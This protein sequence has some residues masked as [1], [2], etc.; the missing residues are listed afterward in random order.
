[1][2]PDDDMR[3]ARSLGNRDPAPV[4]SRALLCYDDRVALDVRD[5]REPV[6]AKAK[7]A[8]PKRLAQLAARKVRKIAAKAAGAPVV[9]KPTPARARPTETPRKTP[10]QLRDLMRA[11]LL[12]R[13]A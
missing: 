1:M 3:A 2:K 11:L 7:G 5:G 4:Y 9:V 6:E 8:A 10:E 12:R 13:S